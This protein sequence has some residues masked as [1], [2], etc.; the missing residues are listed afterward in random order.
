MAKGKCTY[1]LGQHRCAVFRTNGTF[2]SCFVSLFF[3]LLFR[4]RK[5]VYSAIPTNLCRITQGSACT[6]RPFL[7]IGFAP[8]SLAR[9]LPSKHGRQDVG[10]F[11]SLPRDPKN[12]PT[13]RRSAVL[14]AA[15]WWP[16]Y[17]PLQLPDERAA[18][19]RSE[20]KRLPR[21]SGHVERTR[22][23]CPTHQLGVDVQTTPR[24]TSRP[25]LSRSRAC[26]VSR[27]PT[28][29]VSNRCSLTTG[30]K[31]VHSVDPPTQ[32]D[33]PVRRLT[34]LPPHPTNPPSL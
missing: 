11:D 32:S 18:R 17:S 28:R 9:E 16:G 6:V 12:V 25:Y 22:D 34:H 26:K 8:S 7:L 24:G 27:S 31:V 21:V 33:R 19:E 20:S 10:I 14:A 2:S 13:V 3:Q 23:P 30:S 1:S 29:T 5:K 15:S 4:T